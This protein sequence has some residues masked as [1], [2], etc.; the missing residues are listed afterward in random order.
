MTSFFIK[1]KDDK[2]AISWLGLNLTHIGPH[3]GL[4]LGDSLV[5]QDYHH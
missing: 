5:H 1:T 2:I 3:P 4:G